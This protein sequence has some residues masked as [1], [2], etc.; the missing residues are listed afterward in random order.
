[1]GSLLFASAERIAAEA[2]VSVIAVNSGMGRVR[3]HVFY[4]KRG[5]VKKGYG[6]AKTLPQGAE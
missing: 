3:A 6:F 1:M 5:F 4:E 2:G